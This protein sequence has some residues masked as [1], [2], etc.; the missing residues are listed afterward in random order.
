VPA[1]ENGVKKQKKRGQERG[2]TMRKIF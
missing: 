2:E 1:V